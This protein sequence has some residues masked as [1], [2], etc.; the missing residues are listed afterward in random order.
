M[1]T[2]SA[3]HRDHI[4]C[5]HA[6]ISEVDDASRG[7]DVVKL[8]TAV[9]KPFKLDD[10]QEALRDLDIRGM[11]VSEVRGF[12]RQGGHQEMYRGAEYRIDF[13]P[14]LQVELVVGDDVCAEVVDALQAGATT[15][16]IGDGKIWV[17]SVDRI[18][19]IRTGEEG[20]DALM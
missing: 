2:Y 10:V 19:R 14:K 8:V 3:K 20:H 5:I 11:T 15:G 4:V 9:I 13:L 16:R 1:N 7:A 6:V 17:R 18:V 12:G